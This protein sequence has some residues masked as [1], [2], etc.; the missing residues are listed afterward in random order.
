MST[1]SGTDQ[2]HPESGQNTKIGL[3]IPALDEAR[4]IGSVLDS[5]PPGVFSQV[6]VVDNGSTDNT[7]AIAAAH[8][9]TVVREER[10]GYGYACL[11]GMAALGPACLITVFMDGDG[12]DLPHDAMRLVEPILAG[13]ADM[14]IGARRGPSVA[15]GSLMPHQ[16]FG[17]W[18]ACF[19]I[20]ALFGYRYTDLGP[21]RAIV[22]E[23]LRKL[24]MRDTTYGWTV[25]MQVRALQER[26]RVK[27]IAV[28]YRPRIGTS[29]VSG[30]LQASVRA[31]IKIVGTIFRL[32]WRNRRAPSQRP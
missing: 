29:K 22:T 32:R 4:V 30:N 13:A 12:S 2:P 26:M 16:R 8:G 5:L 15:K 21:F 10:R 31:G 17:N 24:E 25:E 18:L 23:K 19:L 20:H 9:A 7:G 27:E 11:A 3:I 1:I 14:V 6:V 28:G